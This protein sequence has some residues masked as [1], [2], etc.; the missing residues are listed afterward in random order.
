VIEKAMSPA[1]QDR[2]ASATELARA[3]GAR[4]TAKRRWRR[5]DEHPGH[6]ACWR[7]VPQSS[8]STYVV[9]VEQGQRANEYS[10]TSTHAA[11]GNRIVKGCRIVT[12]RNLSQAIRAVMNKLG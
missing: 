8:G 5:T 6:V 12:A 2:F 1:P 11:S 7:G 4:A 10:I 9:C 3:L